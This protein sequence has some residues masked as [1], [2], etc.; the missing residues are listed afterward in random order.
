MGKRMFKHIPTH[1]QARSNIAWVANHRV[2]ER[3]R[4]SNTNMGRRQTPKEMLPA[5]LET[6]SVPPE[7]EDYED[8][9]EKR[10]GKTSISSDAVCYITADDA[11]HWVRERHHAESDGRP[12]VWTAKMI[13][14]SKRQK[15]IAFTSGS[16]R[17][18]WISFNVAWVYSYFETNSDRDEATTTKS[19]G[20]QKVTIVF[21]CLYLK[22]N[23]AVFEMIIKR[24]SLNMRHVSRTHRVD[25]D[26]LF[27]GVDVDSNI[28][29]R[30][31]TRNNTLRTF[32]RRYRLPFLTGV[33]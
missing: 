21:N 9:T 5:N 6:S 30:L 24:W 12:R 4:G 7:D 25:L 3:N 20:S 28:S 10:T 23:E 19:C 18:K 11:V 31:S 26:R 17:R 27:G 1:I 32:L 33:I 13:I 14:G 8:V 2:K 16:H 22:N 15:T 29:M